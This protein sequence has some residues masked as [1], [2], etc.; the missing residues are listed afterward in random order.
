MAI[1]D[2]QYVFLF[3]DKGDYGSNNDSG[4]FHKSA[5]GKSFF[6]KEMNLPNPEYIKNSHAFGQIP[7]Y[8][9]GD[10]A[11]PLQH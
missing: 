1:C 6:N 2:A 3:V 9:V 8:L 10:E 7:C 4:V 11:F 5:I